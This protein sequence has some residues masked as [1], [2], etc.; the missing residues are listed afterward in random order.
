MVTKEQ[1]WQQIKEAGDGCWPHMLTLADWCEEN[2]E[3]ELAFGLRWA[4]KWRK[5]PDVTRMVRRE[6]KYASWYRIWRGHQA[7]TPAFIPGLI[8]DELVPRSQC[9]GGFSVA[10]W[11][12]CQTVEMAY[13][14][15][16]AALLRIMEETG[17]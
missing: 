8:F 10:K 7:A 15:L 4:V 2:N 11:Y 17:L 12:R 6:R 5:W 14:R 13:R 1:F 3:M 9:G 16:G